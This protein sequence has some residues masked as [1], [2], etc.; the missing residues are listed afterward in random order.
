MP[1][2]P[3]PLPEPVAMPL[4]DNYA[5]VEPAPRSLAQPLAQP[6]ND[7]EDCATLI[8]STKQ[9]EVP[10]TRN[11]YRQYEVKI[12]R[13]VMEK[14]PHQVKYTDYEEQD[15]EVTYTVNRC[16]TRYKDEQQAYTVP[17]TKQ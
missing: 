5:P 16:E 17:V 12:P 11:V 13:Q 9:V 1:N 14:V 2:M 8:R 15:K 7:C 4:Q 6:A 3:N 10:C